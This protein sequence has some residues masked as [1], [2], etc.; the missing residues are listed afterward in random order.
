M[1]APA[2][3]TMSILSLIA[4]FSVLWIMRVAT[5]IRVQGK[6]WFTTDWSRLR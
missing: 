2:M 3:V 6:I 1:I 5:L 4:T